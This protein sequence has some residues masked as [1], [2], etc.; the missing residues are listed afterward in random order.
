MQKTKMN[1]ISDSRGNLVSLESGKNIPFE[2][3]RIY[4]L[5]GL[6]DEPRGFHA[7]KKLKQFLFCIHGACSVKLDN[8]QSETL[9][10]ISD[11]SEGIFLDQLIW[12]EMYNFSQDCVLMVLADDHYNESDYIRSY[13]DFK[14]YIIKERTIE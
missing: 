2:I 7:H 1:K 13:D 11:P 3:K 6:N 9:I 8:G 12:H 4:Y 10:H 5:Y 14:D